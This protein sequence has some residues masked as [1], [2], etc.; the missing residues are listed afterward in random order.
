MFKI[1]NKLKGDKRGFTLTEALVTLTIL[2]I[3]IT[4][5]SN[6]VLMFIRNYRMAEYRWIAQTMAEHLAN[7]LQSDSGLEALGTA[8]VCEVMYENPTVND[9]G[10]F[11]FESCPELGNITYDSSTFT[12][13]FNPSDAYKSTLENGYIYYISFDEHLYRIH[14]SDLLEQT[15]STTNPGTYETTLKTAAKRP[16]TEELNLADYGEMDAE[17]GIEF[18]IA[19]SAGEYDNTTHAE[20]LDTAEKYLGTGLTANVNVK[21]INRADDR[22]NGFADMNVSLYLNNMNTGERINY[23][24]GT[25][26]LSNKFV[27]GWTKN[28]SGEFLDQR[29]LSGAVTAAGASD[30]TISHYANIVRYHS[31][32]TPKLLADSTQSGQ[33]NINMNLP[34]CFFTSLAVGSGK[35]PQILEPLRDFR[36]QVLKGTVVG[37]WMIEKYYDWSPAFISLTE[38]SKALKGAFRLAAEG[39]AAVATVAVE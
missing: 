36:D 29:P 17:T 33:S 31:V 28:K 18:A 25:L 10:Q 32:N 21:V 27:A 4:L 20:N 24:P 22:I 26:N 3:A 30:D 9:E 6:L 13:T 37:D 7:S 1:M 5:M 11:S 35:A 14:Y 23:T 16:I 12:L 38:N 19:R 8:N 2:L 39:L 15:E 34:L